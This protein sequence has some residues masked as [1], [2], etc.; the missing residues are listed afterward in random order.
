MGRTAQQAGNANRNNYTSP[1][2]EN[3]Y[4]TPVSGLN[5]G[6]APGLVPMGVSCRIGKGCRHYPLPNQYD[7]FDLR[8]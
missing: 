5:I 4:L 3:A 1:S 8:H 2:Y 6:S 7:R